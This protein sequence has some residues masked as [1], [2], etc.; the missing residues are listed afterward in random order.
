MYLNN[1]YLFNNLWKPFFYIDNKSLLLLLHWFSIKLKL[2]L[3]QQKLYKQFKT[4]FLPYFKILSDV[5]NTNKK[6]IVMRCTKKSIFIMLQIRRGL[7]TS[8]SSSKYL[9][10]VSSLKKVME[11]YNCCIKKM[12]NSNAFLKT[13]FFFLNLNLHQNLIYYLNWINDF[14]LESNH[15]SFGLAFFSEIQETFQL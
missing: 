6:K 3:N 7:K 8:N 13:I 2:I 1:L 9:P 11:S 12:L 5:I 15:D 10:V 4:F 14:K